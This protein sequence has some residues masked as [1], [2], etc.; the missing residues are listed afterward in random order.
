[1]RFIPRPHVFLVT[2][3]LVPS[4]APLPYASQRSVFSTEER[5]HQ[6]LRTVSTIR[7]RVPDSSVILL[8]NS[9][10]PQV[11]IAELA[12]AFDLIVDFALCRE[13]TRLRDG[14]FKGSAELYKLLAVIEILH[15]FDYRLLIKLSG[16]Y[17]LTEGFRLGAFPDDRF[18][19]HD[20]GD[21]SIG[22]VLYSVPKPL[23]G[24][25]CKLLSSALQRARTGES[26][27]RLL[28]TGVPEH[29]LR[30]LPVLGVRGS[31]SVNGQ[32]FEE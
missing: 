20:R 4:D 22:T 14:P 25:F 23:E 6:T 13:A 27:E 1:M 16:R 17:E 10:V 19:V 8:E 31:V 15:D 11:T 30:R 21:G 28:W 18:G 29:Q 3:T 32:L 26:I 9:V 7:E 12:G 5:F 24:S 2:S